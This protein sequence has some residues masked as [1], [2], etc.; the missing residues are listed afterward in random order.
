MKKLRCK[1]E[2]GVWYYKKIVPSCYDDLDAPIYELYD[3]NNVLL[4]QDKL[5]VGMWILSFLLPIVGIIYYFVKR[6]E[7]PAKA[8]GA[9]IAGLSGFAVNF[10][11]T[12]I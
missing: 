1:K 8:K 10:F 7:S 11:W 3:E 6:E 4:E 12:L 9:L 5:G 2:F